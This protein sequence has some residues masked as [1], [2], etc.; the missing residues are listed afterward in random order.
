MTI[1]PRRLFILMGLLTAIAVIAFR[2]QALVSERTQI[3]AQR[4]SELT[5]GTQS[6]A[7]SVGRLYDSSGRLARSVSAYLSTADPAPADL[8]AYLA[9]QA[10]DT[11]NDDYIVVLDKR[12][13]VRATSEGPADKGVDFGGP[14]YLS[15]FGA[16]ELRISPATRSRLNGAVVYPL[17]QR[18]LDPSG[19]FKGAVGVNF[20]PQNIRTPDQRKPTEAEISI[21]TTDGRFIA[22]SFMA[23]DENGRVIAPPPPPGVPGGAEASA[24]TL[25]AQ[26]SVEGW[27][28]IVHASYDRAGVLGPWRKSLRD[29]LYMV[30]GMLLVLVLLVWLGMH[31]AGREQRAREA[32]QAANETVN[33]AL[34]DRELLIQEIHHRVKN[35]LVMTAA[36]LKL[37]ARQFKADEVKDAFESTAQRLSSIGRVHE[38]LYTGPSFSTVD[39]ALYLPTLLEEIGHAHGADA[40][41]LAL[42]CEIASVQLPPEKATPV[43]LIIS[44]VVTN[45]FKHAFDGSAPGEITVRGG[46]CENDEVELIVRDNGKGYGKSTAKGSGLGSRLIKSLAEQLGGRFSYM[47]SSGTEFRLVFPVQTVEG[48]AP[49]QG[50]GE[51]PRPAGAAAQSA[52]ARGERV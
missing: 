11:I 32:L 39:L 29:N 4:Q 38:A 46:P 35:S 15:Y 17:I 14:N 31:T 20:R 44:E 47:K 25:D 28:L 27:P 30:S 42:S 26:T 37:Q 19:A 1:T 34:R 18:I 52:Q 41:D 5:S 23:F 43:G 40:K 16:S 2:A 10:Q 8:E 6:L 45:A 3:L 50:A 21:W 36:L 13:R 33:A 9:K 49:P 22:S 12:G 51:S 48:G 7:T 24:G